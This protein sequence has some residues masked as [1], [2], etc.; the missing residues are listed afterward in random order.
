M[1]WVDLDRPVEV[2]QSAIVV[3]LGFVAPRTRDICVGIFWID[4]DGCREIGYG[5]IAIFVREVGE[6]SKIVGKR[7]LRIEL[8]GF[9]VICD[10]IF[11]S[12]LS[13]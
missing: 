7:V 10:G 5:A 11:D 8:D 2:G 3:T 13:L 4:F 9:A 6:A 12:P 1:L